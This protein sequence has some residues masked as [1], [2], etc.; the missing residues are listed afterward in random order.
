[1]IIVH[2]RIHVLCANGN[3]QIVRLRTDSA[4]GSPYHILRCY[5][6]D[7]PLSGTKEMLLPEFL[8]FRMNHSAKALVVGHI[9]IDQMVKDLKRFHWLGALEHF[10]FRTTAMA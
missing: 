1:M 2:V 4:F 7:E 6:G 3:G 8:Y 5:L 9:K 10:V